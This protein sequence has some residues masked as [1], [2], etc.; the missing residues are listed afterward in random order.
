MLFEAITELLMKIS[1]LK[2]D[3][4][5]VSNLLRTFRSWFFPPSSG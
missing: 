1:L 2:Y 5:L 4:T 3:V